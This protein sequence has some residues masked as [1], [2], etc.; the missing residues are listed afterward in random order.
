MTKLA[1]CN[2]ALIA[3]GEAPN[4]TSIDPPDGSVAAQ[5]AATLINSAIATVLESRHWTFA[6]RRAALAK[7]TLA[8][9]S[10]DAATNY[11]TTVVAHGL[12]EAS[13]VSVELVGAALPA[14]LEEGVAYYPTGILT[15]QFSLSETEGGSTID[16]TTNGTG[17]FRVLKESDREGYAFMYALPS[18]CVTERNVVPAGAPDDWPDGNYSAGLPV[19]SP[20]PGYESPLRCASGRPQRIQYH[21][22]LNIAGEQVIYTNI[23]DA[24]LVYS[25]SVDDVTQWPALFQE[26]VVYQLAAGLA[27]GRSKDQRIIDWCLQRAQMLISEANRVDAS[28]SFQPEARRYA[29]DRG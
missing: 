21:R 4:I 13:P 10:A 20:W 8:S 7:V 24:E 14:P 18:D 22:A 25:A 11:I 2:R 6:N 1:L 16:I 12:T 5:L 26:C 27:G 29:W 9:P 17:Q 28:R 3:I 19:P 15:T 23:E